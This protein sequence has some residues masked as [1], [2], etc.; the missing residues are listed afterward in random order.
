[1]SLARKLMS[2]IALTLTLAA[3]END[4][5]PEDQ[6]GEEESVALLKGAGGLLA[7]VLEDSTLIEINAFP[8]SLVSRCPQGGQVKLV[9]AV[10]EDLEGDTVGFGIDML[11]TPSECV[12]AA[13]GIQFTTDPGPA[14]RYQLLVE[15]V[16][17]TF[18][19]NISGMITG[20]V[21]WQLDDRSGNCVINLTLEA[22]PDLI[23]E[24]LTGAYK[25]MLCGHEVEIPAEDL[26]V[27]DL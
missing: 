4:M 15:I 24:T 19:F 23:N 22:V 10:T 14:L 20:G 25:G 18:E 21:D 13:D 2:G 27:V 9:G 6:L 26:L 17:A 1:M 3:C 12:I 11:I 16:A 5:E 8:D 7:Q